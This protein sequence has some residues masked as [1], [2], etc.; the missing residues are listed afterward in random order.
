[1]RQRR[2]A[3][4]VGGLALLVAIT[5]ASL[6]VWRSVG[7]PGPPLSLR[8]VANS[9][10][11]GNTGR[12]DYESLDEPHRLLFIA[13]LGDN[14][15]IAFDT[16][17][18]RVAATIAGTDSV[19]GV[20]VVPSLQRVYAAAAGTHEVIV[21]DEA[22]D[23]VI[24]RITAGDVD[25]L[26]YDPQTQQ[27]FV[28]D[29]SGET[30]AV[31]HARTNTLRTHIALGG[32]AGNTQ[33]DDRSHH[34]FV[35]VQTR[36][37]LAEIDPQTLAIIRRYALPGCL[38]PHG[39]LLDSA[40]GY[41]YVACQF[42]ST[43]V[44]LNLRTKTVDASSSLGLGADVL[45]MD[46][47]LDRLYIAAESGIVTIFDTKEGTL[48]KI[49]QAIFAPNAH[50]VGVDQRSH[51]VYFPLRDIDGKPILRVAEPGPSNG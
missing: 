29:E 51:R 48:H 3:F 5:L 49:G 46:F 26:A 40:H 33:Y 23:K 38:H 4:V 24:E 42:N 7:A 39:M 13:H 41:A 28:S 10:L 16:K 45:A 19:R 14:S 18:N 43:I 9:A 27:V 22:S 36:N 15:V 37:D 20:L 6:V 11:S 21:I 30:D 25:G 12:L 17:R 35:A 31:I 34:I 32:Q 1:V 44:R 8:V 47:G 2:R 50:V